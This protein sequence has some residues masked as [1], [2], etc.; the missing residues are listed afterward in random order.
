MNDVIIMM[1]G[2]LG[3]V[4]STFKNVINTHFQSNNIEVINKSKVHKTQPW[5]GVG[6]L[7]YYNQAVKIRTDALPSQ[8][9]KILLNIEKKLG[10][11]RAEA[12]GNRILDLDILYYNDWIINH[13]LVT[14]PHPRLHQRKFCTLLLVE[15]IPDYIH[16]MLLKTNM[17]LNNVNTDLLS[18]EPCED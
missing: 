7:I 9:M 1:G 18:V 14:I 12:N 10:R 3:D 5:G 6:D 11:T 8:L 16:P 17:E 13:N 15:L 2:N 4:K